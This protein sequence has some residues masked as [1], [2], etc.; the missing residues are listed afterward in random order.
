MLEHLIDHNE[1]RQ[2]QPEIFFQKETDYSYHS[3]LRWAGSK[4]DFC[5]L[6][7]ALHGV[8]V[9]NKD[10][11]KAPFKDI[12]SELSRT[13]NIEITKEIYGERI[14]I[15]TRQKKSCF[16]DVLKDKGLEYDEK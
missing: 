12:V 5:E 4:A 8:G 1:K 10:G 15:L 14:R 13:F 16:I 11:Q 2:T 9:I 6:V 7:T 3:P